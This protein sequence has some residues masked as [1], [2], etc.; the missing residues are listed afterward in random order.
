MCYYWYLWYA[1][2]TTAPLQCHG[3]FHCNSTR[4]CVHLNN[5]CDGNEDCPDGSDEVEESCSMWI[6]IIS[7]Y[8]IICYINS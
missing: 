4:L 6:V 2:A 1:A 7:S 5:V 3:K 8:H